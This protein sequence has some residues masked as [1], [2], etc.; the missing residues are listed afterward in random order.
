[1]MISRASTP[2]AA[3]AEAGVIATAEVVVTTVTEVAAPTATVIVP[4][5][6]K[7]VVNPVRLKQISLASPRPT[8]QPNS[9]LPMP[10]SNNSNNVP[11]AAITGDHVVTT[12]VPALNATPVPMVK[13]SVT[14]VAHV[15]IIMAVVH[16]A[17]IPM[18]AIAGLVLPTQITM[19]AA[20]TIIHN[21]LMRNRL[22]R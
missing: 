16:V 10:H 8:M 9:R 21:N 5:D 13:S 20:E 7:I 1:M 6:A 22:A 12:A 18:V 11:N 17:I 19:M 15:A 14:T 3:T 4:T 2:K